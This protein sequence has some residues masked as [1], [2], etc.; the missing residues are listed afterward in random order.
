MS[1]A[2]WPLKI[3]VSPLVSDNHDFISLRTQLFFFILYSF[4]KSSPVHLVQDLESL[5]LILSCSFFSKII[6]VVKNT[7]SEINQRDMSFFYV[8]N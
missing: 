1:Y 2:F 4:Y 3:M 5:D 8:S 6:Y 7:S